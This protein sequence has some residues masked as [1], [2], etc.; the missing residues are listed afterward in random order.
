[1]KK[2]LLAISLCLSYV[3]ASFAQERID[4][5]K[6][7]YIVDGHFFKTLSKEDIMSLKGLSLFSMRS[8]DQQRIFGYM[9]N[10]NYKM[11]NELLEKEVPF[12]YVKNGEEFLKLYQD[13]II[14]SSLIQEKAKEGK[15]L[16]EGMPLDAFSLTDFDGNVWDNQR[17]EGKVTVV[18]V[19]YSG[20]GP[21]LKEMP[22]IS[23]WKNEFPEANFLSVDYESKE[24]MQ[25]IVEKRGFTWTHLYND[26]YFTSWVTTN[27]E[28]T[29][30][31]LTI[32]IDKTGVIRHV[33][34]GT[35]EEKRAAVVESIKNCLK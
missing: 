32:V 5:I 17:I 9:N 28:D 8:A 7:S 13:K 12:K 4:T 29:G 10:S 6:C 16:K 26:R 1:M 35:N 33:V 34:H 22:I 2:I 31:P 23:E 20:C 30:F 3:T 21:C 15:V 27:T 14:W 25:S 19:W 11:S 24:K 18:N